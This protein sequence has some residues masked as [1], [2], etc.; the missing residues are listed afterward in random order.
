MVAIDRIEPARGRAGD[1]VTFYGSGFSSDPTEISAAFAQI[2]CPGGPQPSPYIRSETQ[3]SFE[4]PSGIP[5]GETIEASIQ[6]ADNLESDSVAWLALPPLADMPTWSVPGQVP[7]RNE[8]ANLEVVIPDSPQAKDYERLVTLIE[9]LLRNVVTQ[10]GALLTSDGSGIV[11]LAP[12]LERQLLTADS[13]ATAGLAWKQ[14][15]RH[16][17]L[18]WGKERDSGGTN[19]GGMVANGDPSETST[20]SGEHGCPF[21][22][23]VEQIGVLVSQ[24]VTP[25]S[26]SLLDQVTLAVNGVVV[27]DS[28]AGLALDVNGSHIAAPANLRVNTGDRIELRTYGTGG[29][30]LRHMGYVRLAQQDNLVVGDPAVVEDL[31]AVVVSGLKATVAQDLILVADQALAAVS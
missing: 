26:T 23:V 27:Y 25:P 19:D 18:R 3:L 8:R 21:D 4:V 22:G 12:G 24:R 20:T 17:M 31:V 9:Y 30:V 6:R 11:P 15:E 1:I 5:E 2:E 29:G 28:G 10:E 14:H 7:G 13:D 16:L